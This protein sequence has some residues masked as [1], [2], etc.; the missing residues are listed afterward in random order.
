MKKILVVEDEKRINDVI[1]KYLEAE[2]YKV[3]SVYDGQQA[4]EA[5]NKSYDLVVLDIMLPK[6]D[7]QRVCQSI[8]EQ[9][10]V[11][12][13]MLTALND[14]KDILKSYEYG[15]DEYVSKPFSPKVLVARIK[16]LFKIASRPVKA[17][18]DNQKISIDPLSRKASLDG[19]LLD[20][21]PIEYKLLHY[22][23]ENEDILLSRDNILDYVWGYDYFGEARVVDT[24]VKNLRKK[25]LHYKDTIKTVKGLGY[26]YEVTNED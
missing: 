13:M 6:L 19:Q 12:V 3:D 8:K 20:L 21:T 16:A 11:L 14:D 9:S 24:H 7:G 5:F 4:L 2:G 25:L 18:T 10:D 17:P 15:A 22:F 1:V 23:L 26:R